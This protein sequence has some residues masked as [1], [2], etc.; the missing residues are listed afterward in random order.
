MDC[1][2]T[3]ILPTH[4]LSFQHNNPNYQTLWLTNW[5]TFHDWLIQICPFVTVMDDD[6]SRALVNTII[7][8]CIFDQSRIKAVA[9]RLQLKSHSRIMFLERKGP[10]AFLHTPKS[11]T[12]LRVYVRALSKQRILPCERI[13]TAATLFYSRARRWHKSANTGGKAAA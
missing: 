1:H 7:R 12:F 5:A 13:F 8:V 6:A 3:V 9:P 10:T 11:S 4:F 2:G